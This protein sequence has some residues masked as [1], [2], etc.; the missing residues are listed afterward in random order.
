[1]LAAATSA[2]DLDETQHKRA[3]HV[4][5]EI[6]RALDGVE[7][8]EAGDYR[9]FGQRM[10]ESHASLRDDYDVSCEELD[11]VVALAERCPGVYG[12]RMTGGGFGGC[13]ILLVDAAAAEAV[14]RAV[15]SGFDA[16]FGRK[17]PFF[18]TRPAVGASVLE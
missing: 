6:A 7:A 1:M 10:Y 2:G 11:E 14:G 5:G 3:R 12:A 13:A 17:C 18:A 16:R 9:R 8:L 15:R 4:I